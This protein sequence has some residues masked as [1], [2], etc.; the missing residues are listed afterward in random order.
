MKEAK[1]VAIFGHVRP[2]GDCVGSTTG[3]YNYIQDNYPSIHADLYLENF[4]ESYKILRGASD[5]KPLYTS[6]NN[7]GLP[8]D[9]VFL[10]DT[11][12]FE[13]VGANGAECLQTAK[14]SINIDHHISNPLNL[15]TLNLVE[16]EASSASEVLYVNLDKEK[17]SRETANSLYLGI[18]HDTGAF[19]FSCTGKRTM[20][21]VGDLIEKGIDF[22]KIV[23]ETYYTRT[24]KQT[25]VTGFVMENCKLGLGGKVV[26][27]HIT[28]EDMQR[29]DVTPVELSN[30]ID[31]IREVGGTEVALFLYPVNGKYK[32]SLRSNYIVDVNAIA[33]EFGGGGHTRAAGGD[34]NDTPEAAIEKILGL[35]EKQL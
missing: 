6:E 1:T 11:P 18:V 26:Y 12:S 29:F 7:A 13:R 14:K 10:M 21:V 23:N 5:A 17:V 34:T 3:I 22:A 16:P 9:L 25:L 32:I 2:D 20:Q 33:R 8:Y 30:V 28:P 27:A 4:P 24:Y 35:I 15:C 31:T 19:K